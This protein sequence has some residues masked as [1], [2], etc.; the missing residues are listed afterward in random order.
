MEEAKQ[1]PDSHGGA[2]SRLLRTG[3]IMLVGGSL[4]LAYLTNLRFEVHFGTVLEGLEAP[5]SFIFP[6]DHPDFKRE[7]W[8]IVRFYT[9]SPH[10]IY[11]LDRPTA[12]I[13][14][15]VVGLVGLYW[16]SATRVRA[17]S[18]IFLLPALT[19]G[20]VGLAIAPLTLW[21]VAALAEQGLRNPGAAGEIAGRA[22][23]TVYVGTLLSLI[24]LLAMLW[25]R[26]RGDSNRKGGKAG[27]D[28]S[29]SVAPPRPSMERTRP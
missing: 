12:W 16:Y 5:W 13:F 3:M 20:L 26:T 28:G 23:V 9:W 25:S 14:I 2:R 1:E 8:Q 15:L 7:F 22:A 10:R 27:V 19:P 24:C 18:V 6:L 11:Y 21:K 29:G 17:G 4:V